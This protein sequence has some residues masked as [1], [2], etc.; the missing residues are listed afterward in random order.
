M[1]R[2][3][4]VGGLAGAALAVLTLLVYCPSF[5]YPFVNI[6]DPD[7]AFQNP[8]VQ[9]GLTADGTR[10]AFTTFDCGNWHPLTWLSL[11]LDCEVYGGLKPGGFHLTNVLLHAANTLLLFLVLG[12]MTGLLW[13][14]AVVAALF[15]LHP[16]HVESVA[17]VAERKDVLSTL[18]WMLT[19]A[20]YVHYVRRPGVCRYLLVVMALGLGLMAK[21]MLVTL[22]FVLLLLD[23]WPLRRVA[24]SSPHKPDAPA[25]D[26][27]NSSPAR[28][29]CRPGSLLL[30]KLP[31]LALVAA[32]CG[33]TFLAQSRAEAVA[34]LEAFPLAV[35]VGNALLAYV[36]YLGKM[37][38]PAHLAVYYPHSGAD[39]SVVGALGAG[40]LLVV[41]TALVLGPGRRRPY[42]AVGWLWYVGTL[43][44][45]IGLVQ[46]G[47][48]ALA[49]RYTYVPL[50][51]IFL[52]LTWGAADLA[53]AWR[54]PRPY[55]IAAAAAVLS[56]CVAL[57]WVQVGYWKSSLDL[58]AHA[59][60]VTEDSG[61]AHLNLGACYYERHML[62][63][64]KR[65]FERAAALGP[66]RAGPH[67]KLG[68]VLADLDLWE[69]AAAEYRRAVELE[70]EIA[71]LHFNLGRA[72]VELGRPEEALPEFHKASDLDPESASSHH[73][74]GSALRDL[75]RLE[76]AEAEYRRAIELDPVSALSHH[77][78][79]SVFAEMGRFEEALVAYRRAIEFDP[80]DA[81]PHSNLGRAL[82]EAGRLEEALAEYRRAVELGDQQAWPRLQACERW[83]ALR[84]RLPGLAAGRDRPADNAERLAFAELFR[85][86]IEGRYAIAARLYAE[87]FD[88]DP[89]LADD[90][91]AATR[92]R[93]AGAAAS[94]GCGQGRD[95]ARLDETEKIRLRCQAL[96]WLR[97]DLAAWTKQGQGD[98]ARARAALQKALRSWR[99]DARLAGVRDAGALDRL[100]EAERA[101]WQGL[102]RQVDVMLAGVSAPARKQ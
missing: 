77:N 45:V 98:K 97:A 19:L 35:R 22:P 4:R 61:L 26:A 82:Q 50:I 29:A 69:Q 94:A 18:F 7:Y 3:H 76:E 90:L 13:R 2:D 84:A 63:D 81:Q 96:T 47:G 86:P 6:D 38:W 64:A 20:A 83:R 25:R 44:P 56:A 31:L 1:T 65:E 43:V 52:L 40:V 33:V 88:A 62:T 41:I 70:P 57:S 48:Q 66:G 49:D 55:L 92:L 72:L 91:R 71:W 12:R 39:V 23:Y 100:P 17:W 99:R 75:G 36:T 68:T 101:E 9:A 8:H 16:L 10:W 51:G 53:A 21:P 87:A 58:W 42:L 59:A 74:L 80:R 46:V 54:V 89:K 37:L 32:S 95:G 102:W 5:N 93:A 34:P 30:E 24:G 73:N 67:A 14:S 79:G 78:L 27:A 60:A 15:A 11:Q 85:Q 28:R